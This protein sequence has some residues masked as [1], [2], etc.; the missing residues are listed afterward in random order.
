M[1]QV[2]FSKIRT[3][4]GLIILVSVSLYVI[5]YNNEKS[6]SSLSLLSD[7]STI[8][9]VMIQILAVYGIIWQLK[10]QEHFSV[11][12]F[13]LEVTKAL[14]TH[15]SLLNKLKLNDITVTTEDIDQSTSKNNDSLNS[16][17]SNTEIMELLNV[18]ETMS[19]LIDKGAIDFKD[20]NGPFAYRFFKVCDH[21]VIQELELVK[22][23]AY[24]EA[25]YRLHRQWLAFRDEMKMETE[26]LN[27][28][29]KNA[30]IDYLKLS[31]PVNKKLK[32][33]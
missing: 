29:S 2:S 12:N 7:V 32:I 26:Q 10:Q 13:M 21:K 28:L 30:K 25:I 6:I 22:D 11:A 31:E 1:K 15:T 4:M 20:I 33:K 27:P 18:Y 19:T 3:I 23:A 8:A 24:Y 5:A 17:I 14:S 9:M 16:N